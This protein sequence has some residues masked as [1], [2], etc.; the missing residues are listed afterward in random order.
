MNRIIFLVT[1]I[2][3]SI[4]GLVFS[5]NSNHF[6]LDE[7]KLAIEFAGLSKLENFIEKNQGITLVEIENNHHYLLK[8]ILANP[9]NFK[10]ME[11]TLRGGETP[12][13]I[14]PFIWGLCLGIVGLVLVAIL[15]EEKELTKK[16][17]YGCIVGTAISLGLRFMFAFFDF[18][19]I[20]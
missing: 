6:I 18:S 1:I 9:N 4:N 17:L 2:L 3:L 15:A 14:P 19:F 16:A 10:G 11:R 12:L 20:F 5:K 13:G 8:G 7:N